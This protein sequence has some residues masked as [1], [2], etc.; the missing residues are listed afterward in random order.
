LNW[1]IAWLDFLCQEER[2]WTRE[3]KKECTGMLAGIT[4]TSLF[5]R[6]D[7]PPG[8]RQV[9]A[10]RQRYTS[11]VLGFWLGWFRL[12]VVIVRR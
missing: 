3:A 9:T 11:G 7:T 10:R 2:E 1:K 5:S 8:G 12:I 4:K 6:F